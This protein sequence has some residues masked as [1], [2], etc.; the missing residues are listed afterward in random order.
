M[1]QKSTS[2]R[3]KKDKKEKKGEKASRK[4]QLSDEAAPEEY[5]GTS[6]DVSAVFAI[7]ENCEM[8]ESSGTGEFSHT[9][10]ISEF[11]DFTDWL[12]QRTSGEFTALSKPSWAD[13]EEYSDED[14]VPSCIDARSGSN[15]IPPFDEWAVWMGQH[16]ESPAAGVRLWADEEEDSDNGPDE[17]VCSTI[18]QHQ[19][20]VA[21]SGATEVS[22]FHNFNGWLEQRTSGA[23][24]S[25]DK[26]AWADA[27]DSDDEQSAADEV[28][29][30]NEQSAV[31]CSSIHNVRKTH[32][33]CSMS[34]FQDGSVRRS[35]SGIA[36]HQIPFRSNAPWVSVS[37]S[38]EEEEFLSFLSISMPRGVL[39]VLR[40][41]LLRARTC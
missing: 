23:C 1:K 28:D 20:F 2:S 14:T 13:E 3:S 16:R 11:D 36:R 21:S 40:R 22:S 7:D 35:D 30:D 6:Q 17:E 10:E 34:H 15:A 39:P 27:V 5:K 8:S 12:G 32:G 4:S 31:V 38:E 18:Q 9:T 37:D 33:S 19:C 25:L 26:P 24:N 41:D 29:S